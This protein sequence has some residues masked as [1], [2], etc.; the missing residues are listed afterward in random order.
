[1]SEKLASGGQA[2]HDA[3][4]KLHKKAANAE[5]NRE[6]IPEKDMKRLEDAAHGG[7]FKKAAAAAMLG[8]DIKGLPD[9]VKQAEQWNQM[10]QWQR[11][12]AATG[13]SAAA[14]VS[15]FV[16]GLVHPDKE[17]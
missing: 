10:P 12:A 9:A 11:D 5:K 1:V 3:N 15:G 14:K 17:P 6:G 13:L 16:E 8:T 2:L 7:P 4:K